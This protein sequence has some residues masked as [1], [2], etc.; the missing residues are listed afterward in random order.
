MKNRGRRRADPAKESLSD[1]A[2]R[3]YREPDYLQ[4]FIDAVGWTKLSELLHPACAFSSR[5]IARTDLDEFQQTEAIGQA[6]A[7]NVNLIP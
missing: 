6:F 7:I 5:R 3:T 1:P 2:E 4:R